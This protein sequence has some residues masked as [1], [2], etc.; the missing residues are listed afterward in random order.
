MLVA[1]RAHNRTSAVSLTLDA[2]HEFVYVLCALRSLSFRESE[3]RRSVCA[4]D[5]QFSVA[6]NSRSSGVGRERARCNA[7]SKISI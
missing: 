3:D 4:R 5:R 6:A 2:R 1:A 7:K